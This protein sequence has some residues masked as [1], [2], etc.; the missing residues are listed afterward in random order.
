LFISFRAY[1]GMVFQFD[2]VIRP[3]N[4]L[5]LEQTLAL[6]STVDLSYQHDEDCG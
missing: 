6:D 3:S 4:Q 1:F 2:F 5:F